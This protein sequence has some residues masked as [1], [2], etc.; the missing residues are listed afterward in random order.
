M[1]RSLAILTIVGGHFIPGRRLLGFGFLLLLVIAPFLAALSTALLSF[2]ELS[3]RMVEAL[4]S[5]TYLFIISLIW[6]WSAWVAIRYSERVKSLDGLKTGIGLLETI[7]AGVL[8]WTTIGIGLVVI[9]VGASP[10]LDD[11]QRPPV[12]QSDRLAWE[13][14]GGDVQYRRLPEPDGSIVLL[15]NFELQGKPLTGEK[16]R[17]TFANGYASEYFLTDDQGQLS[18]RLP[19]G[20]WRLIGPEL[21]SYRAKE[22]RY[23]ILDALM[24]GTRTFAVSVGS[25]TTK[26]RIRFWIE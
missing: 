4:V 16:I 10:F 12:V 26:I 22:V 19:A 13:K 15:C 20:Q 3:P 23:E 11:G 14:R 21:T 1:K 6:I 7:G 2:Q 17:L 5:A 25:P 8:A 18:I 24:D 9:I